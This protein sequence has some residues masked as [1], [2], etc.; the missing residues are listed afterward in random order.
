MTITTLELQK[1]L[2]SRTLH[3][4]WIARPGI[5]D[6]GRFVYVAGKHSLINE[7]LKVEGGLTYGQAAQVAET[8]FNE[9][10]CIYRLSDDADLVVMMMGTSADA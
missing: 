8:V 7:L 5:E 4:V 9:A 10:D 1:T 6:E 2:P 3:R